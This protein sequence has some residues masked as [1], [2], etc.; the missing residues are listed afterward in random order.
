G[1]DVQVQVIKYDEAAKRVS[2]GMK[3]LQDNPW[4][5][6]DTRYPVGSIVKGKVTNIA[7][8][9]A[10][11]E[12]ENGIEGLVHVSEMSWFKNNLSPSKILS[13]GQEVEVMI[14]DIDAKSHR[15]SLGIKQCEKNPWQAFSDS[16]AVGDVLEVVVKN[17]TEFGLFVG[18]DSGVDG[19]VHVSDITSG[20]NGEE[21]LKNFKKDDKIKVVVLGSNYE[22]ER[23]SLGIKQL[24]NKNFKEE[25]AKIK[26]D[27]VISCAVVGVKKDLIE[28]ELDCGLKAIIKKADLGK[29]KSDQKTDNFEVGD[30]IDAKV[31]SFNNITG[32]VVLSIKDAQSDEQESY[33][34]SKNDNSG[35]TLG[36]ILGDVLQE[37]RS[38]IQDK[39][40]KKSKEAEAKKEKEEKAKAKD[41]KKEDKAEAK[42]ED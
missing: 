25:I 22:K 9:G 40:N 41:S 42:K 11:V 31:V 37:S 10:F 30:R 24:E 20:D 18:F 2:L 27:T 21:L 1:Q 19:L 15:I 5:S 36:S 7:N 26:A 29:D 6:I 16:H 28:V 35:A 39:E 38:I 14:L 34:Y 33:I 3:Q 4:E 23:I 32:K 12:I 13:N 8:Y 17:A